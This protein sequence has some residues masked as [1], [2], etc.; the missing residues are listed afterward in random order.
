[1]ASL[2]AFLIILAMWPF[3]LMW[4]AYVTVVMWG[5]F[6]QPYIGLAAPSIHATAG[7]LMILSLATYH[8]QPESKEQEPAEQVGRAFIYGFFL[9]LCAL[10]TAWIWKWLQWGVA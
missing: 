10:G 5:W 1:M 3:A 2:V 7:A 6:I 4:K 8:V 9:P